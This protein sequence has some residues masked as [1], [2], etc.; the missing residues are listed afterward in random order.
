MQAAAGLSEEVL[1]VEAYVQ[2]VNAYLAM[3]Q[4]V[5]AAAAAE[6]GLWILKRVPEEA[7]K[8][9]SAGEAGRGE[10]ERLLTLK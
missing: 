4:P 10:Y 3:K 7:F 8:K 6:R 2:I 1:A 5:Q 9:V